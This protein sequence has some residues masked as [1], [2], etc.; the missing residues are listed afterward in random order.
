MPMLDKAH[1]SA[2][3]ANAKKQSDNLKKA[4]NASKKLGTKR[5]I[6]MKLS[7]RHL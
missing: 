4:Y 5:L 1:V 2:L 6:A 3:R 7:R